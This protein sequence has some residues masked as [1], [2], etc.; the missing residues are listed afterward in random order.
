MNK[1]LK[2]LPLIYL[3]LCNSSSADLWPQG[4]EKYQIRKQIIRDGCGILS[5]RIDVSKINYQLLVWEIFKLPSKD[6]NSENTKSFDFFQTIML[7]TIDL[8]EAFQVNP[9]VA[10]FDDV[11]PNAYAFERDVTSRAR[12]AT[13][14]SVFLGRN[15]IST[16][17]LDM[18]KNGVL[19]TFILA[20]EFSHLY[21]YKQNNDLAT[22][23]FELQADYL[24]GWYL[25]TASGKAKVEFPQPFLELVKQRKHHKQ[26]D[27]SFLW[28]TNAIV[29]ID[30]NRIDQFLERKGATAFKSADAHGVPR[31]RIAAIRA[32]F[33]AGSNKKLLSQVYDD[34]LSFVA[35]LR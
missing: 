1:Y 33:E 16:E 23:D 19:L 20:H 18:D 32:G 30:L 29:N 4:S 34:G 10:Y 14:G 11:L 5:S 26:M 24:A 8:G 7:I 25:A 27:R 15:L 22:R 21:Q 17:E 13:D 28:A 3:L 35:Q 2:I 12:N 9:T 6:D 31:L